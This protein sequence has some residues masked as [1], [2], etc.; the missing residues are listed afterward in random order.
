MEL[1]IQT[2]T[3]KHFGDFDEWIFR[4]TARLDKIMGIPISLPGRADFFRSSCTFQPIV[5]CNSVSESPRRALSFGVENAARTLQGLELEENQFCLF[6]PP[7][8]QIRSSHPLRTHDS[9]TLNFTRLLDGVP[10]V[11]TTLMA[12]RCDRRKVNCS[13]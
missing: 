7:I 1:G 11:R 4:P 8:G 9:K 12:N 13:P 2:V 6:H 10:G 5:E 3:R